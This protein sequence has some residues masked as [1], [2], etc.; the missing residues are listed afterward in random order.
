MPKV[1]VTRGR[2]INYH[3]INQILSRI[4]WNYEEV[5]MNKKC[6]EVTEKI[7]TVLDEGIPKKT[8]L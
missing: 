7:Q 2:N 4:K 3:I 1:I 5:D 6:G 8:V